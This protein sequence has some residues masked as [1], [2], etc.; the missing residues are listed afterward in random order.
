MKKHALPISTTFPASGMMNH[1]EGLRF[2]HEHGFDAMDFNFT[3]ALEIYGKDWHD[4][5]AEIRRECE[6]TGMIVVSGHLPFRGKTPEIL[7]ES[8]VEAIKMAGE[9]GIERAVMHPVGDGKMPAGDENHD[10]WYA[11]NIEYYSKYIPLADKAG[12]KLVTENMRDAHQAS[13]CHRYASTADELIEIA[14]PLGL[15]ICWDFGHAHEAKLDHYTELLKIGKR[16]TMTHINDNWQ[17]PDDEHL[18]PFYGTGDW[19]AACRGLREIGYSQ[20][21]NFELKYKKLPERIM[22]QAVDLAA[23][24]GE[25]MLDMIFENK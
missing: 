7:H 5:V 10:L 22:P 12:F 2:L 17:G 16:L 25:L 3:A 19:D 23:A 21:L 6:R 13:G 8:L 20:P 9:L 14:D 15:E 11:K 24:I 1:V 18:P 4:M